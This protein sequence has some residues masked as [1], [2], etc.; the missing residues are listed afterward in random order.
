MG[1]RAIKI[2]PPLDTEDASEPEVIATELEG[3]GKKKWANAL[4]FQQPF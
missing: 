1:Y 4:S 2:F 3:S